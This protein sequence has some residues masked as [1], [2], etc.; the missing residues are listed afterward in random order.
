MENLLKNSCFKDNK[1]TDHGSLFDYIS[2]Y[3]RNTKVSI[4]TCCFNNSECL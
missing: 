1:S 4:M 2:T 3:A